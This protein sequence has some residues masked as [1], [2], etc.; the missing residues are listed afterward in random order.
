MYEQLI[1]DHFIAQLVNQDIFLQFI[2]IPFQ[3]MEGYVG[4]LISLECGDPG[5]QNPSSAPS[6]FIS[7]NFA[8]AYRD[9]RMLIMQ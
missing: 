3:I 8:Y 6:S 9:Y 1:V 7:I 4:K 5:F 2:T